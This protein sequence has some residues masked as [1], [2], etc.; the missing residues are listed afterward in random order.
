MKVKKAFKKIEIGDIV[1]TNGDFSKKT[2]TLQ[3]G[4]VVA[5]DEK[6]FYIKGTKGSNVNRWNIN[7]LE[8]TW[9]VAWNNKEADVEIILK[10]SPNWSQ[11]IKEKI[12]DLKEKFL[13]LFTQ[14]PYKSFKKSKIVDEKNMLT[15]EGTEI[16]LNWLLMK[17]ADEFKKEVVDK[18]LKEQTEE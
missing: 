12:M 18:L 14:E 17:Y 11:L 15:D 5:I 10:A 9:F 4:K 3:Q 1:L 2:D 7:Y 13:T 6:G 8:D 16:F